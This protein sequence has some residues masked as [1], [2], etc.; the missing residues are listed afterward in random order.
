MFSLQHFLDGACG[1]TGDNVASPAIPALKS[2]CVYVLSHHR[3][4][5]P[6]VTKCAMGRVLKQENAILTNV[7]VSRLQVSL[8][9]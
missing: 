7:Q 9:S 1:G 4:M 6:F 3:S 8:T 2:A 5:L